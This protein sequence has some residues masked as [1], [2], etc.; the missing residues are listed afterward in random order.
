[1]KKKILVILS[2]LIL[3]VISIS[4]YLVYKKFEY[5]EKQEYY[6]LSSPKS[7][8]I[9]IGII[10]DSWVGRYSIEKQLQNKLKEE[11][12]IAEVIASSHP[13]GRTKEIYENLFKNKGEQYSSKF[14]VENQPKYCIV[15]AGIN[16]AARHMGKDYYVH[17]M[18]LIIITLL[19]YN[20]TPII[21]ELTAF[22][23]EKDHSQKNII[24]SAGNRISEYVD[25]N[26][27]NNINAYRKALYK[28][29]QNTTL[30]D[31]VIFI[32]VDGLGIDYKNH[33]NLYTDPLHLN[34]KGYE[35]LINGFS[36]KIISI[37]K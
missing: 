36:D 14:I 6:R 3:I 25:G 8:S 1:M 19:N 28:H 26:E 30:L 10:G 5:A 17:H 34:E 12:Y 13:G 18:D 21:L 27:I 32:D 35:K 11:G 15:M 20:I 4:T 29:L 33:P 23:V 7:D 22:G 24:S 37:E 16:D 2:I 31:K 9:K